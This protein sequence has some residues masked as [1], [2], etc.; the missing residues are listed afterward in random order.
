MMLSLE[1]PPISHAIEWPDIFGSGA[2]AVNKVV[3]LMWLSVAL[4]AAFFFVAGRK[5]QLVPTGVQNVGE[6][7]ADFVREGIIMQTMGKDG[8]GYTPFLLTIFSFVFVCNIWEIVPGAQMPVNAR[9][10]LPALMAVLVWVI[11]NVV[12]FKNQG[13]GYLKNV[14]FPPGV[15]WPLY[16]LVTPIEFVS[17]FLVR[18]LSLSVRLFANMLAGHLLLI[19]FAVLSTALWESTK[20]GAIAP[21]ALLV[22]LTGF[23]ILVA[24][25]Q[26]YIFTILTA[27]FIGGSQ[28]PEH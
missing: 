18:P 27:V 12:G 11:F 15:P 22:A 19:S 26:A 10:A 1:F 2:F 7:V 23:E 28:H 9:I 24:G 21:F 16:F 4:T 14:L 20:V 3:L 8:L 13:L 25:L 5:Q 6:S 17:T